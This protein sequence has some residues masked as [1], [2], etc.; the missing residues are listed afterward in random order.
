MIRLLLLRVVGCLPF[1]ENA[2]VPLDPAGRRRTS[3][4]GGNRG[5]CRRSTSRLSVY[6]DL[7]D[8]M[9]VKHP[10]ETA[11]A[12]FG[13]SFGTPAKLTYCSLE[14]A[15]CKVARKF[16][17]RRSRPPAADRSADGGGP[18]VSILRACVISSL[19]TLVA[20]GSRRGV[21]KSR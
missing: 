12:V 8:P 11:N 19:P 5:R 1:I 20:P 21:A 7:T 2:I 6:G 9:A 15:P 14:A 3:I 4:K 17:A 10:R 18:V 13:G 16:R